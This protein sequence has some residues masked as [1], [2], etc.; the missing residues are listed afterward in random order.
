MQRSYDTQS[1]YN[2]E[3][4]LCALLVIIHCTI[5]KFEPTFMYCVGLSMLSIQ[6]C[7]HICCVHHHPTQS[8]HFNQSWSMLMIYTL[9]HYPILSDII[10]GFNHVWSVQLP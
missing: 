4:T 2:V 6:L 8:H 3:S 9:I 10:I 7:T 1:D 5:T